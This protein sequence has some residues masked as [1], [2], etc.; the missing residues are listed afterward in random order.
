MAVESELIL[1]NK[2]PVTQ[3]QILNF[4][5]AEEGRALRVDESLL[6]S[7]RTITIAFFW[8]IVIDT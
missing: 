1:K 7:I 5:S 3:Y 4:D 2:E 6:N 8:R